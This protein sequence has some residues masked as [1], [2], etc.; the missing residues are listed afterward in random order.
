MEKFELRQLSQLGPMSRFSEDLFSFVTDYKL[1]IKSVVA[2]QPYSKW[3]A[4]GVRCEV[5]KALRASWRRAW[6]AGQYWPIS[7]EDRLRIL[8]NVANAPPEGFAGQYDT[9]LESDTHLWIRHRPDPVMPTTDLELYILI[10]S[11]VTRL[12]PWVKDRHPGTVLVIPY[13]KSSADLFD[14]F[15]ATMSLSAFD[16][17]YAIYHP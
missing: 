12:V 11:L 8:G 1:A 6:A 14:R 3:E 7:S 2:V 5:P 16:Q 9:Y 13:E 10:T 15:R 4:L 17:K